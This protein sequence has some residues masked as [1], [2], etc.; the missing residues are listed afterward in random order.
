MSYPY[1]PNSAQSPTWAQPPSQPTYGSGYEPTDRTLYGQSQV[2]ATQGFAQLRVHLKPGLWSGWSTRP[3]VRI[4]GVPV[5]ATW[6]TNTFPVPAGRHYLQV[7]TQYL[8]EMGPTA[9]E[10]DARPGIATDVYYA[11]PSGGLMFPGSIGF[12][13]QTNPGMVFQIIM[14]GISVALLLFAFVVLLLG[15]ALV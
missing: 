12:T 6:G 13:P 5:V 14:M 1:N 9:I 10:V 7:S 11:A 2:P 3:N 15:V 8:F 4:N